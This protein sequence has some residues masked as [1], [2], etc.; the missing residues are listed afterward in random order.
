MRI[1]R[2]LYLFVL[3]LPAASAAGDRLTIAVAS[4]F[5]QVALELAE[6]FARDTGAAVRVSTGS[7]GKL[8]GQIVN[9]APFD[10]FLAA[11]AVRPALLENAGEGLAGTRRTYAIGS[12]VFW[13]RDPE[14]AV[15]C[16]DA[17]A[18]LDG[19]LAIANPVTAPYG[20]AAKEYLVAEG[21]WEVLEPS[22]VYGESAAQTLQFVATGNAQAGLVA[23][24]HVRNDSLP[25]ASCSWPVPATLH[26]PIE[27]QA[28]VIA[29][30]GRT[31]LAQEFIDFLGGDD[32]RDLILAAGYRIPEDAE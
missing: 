30:S 18:N 20:R 16:T 15:Q 22:L 7:T 2:L 29:S 9:G 8:Y 21:L 17:L 3:L 23:A 12:L 28:I 25:P 14:L 13:S 1:R 10:V 11:D 27:Q 19:R 32:A 31:D 26:A 4:N 24:S 6:A 5:A